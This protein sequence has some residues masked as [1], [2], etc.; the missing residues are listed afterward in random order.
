MKASAMIFPQPNIAYGSSNRKGAKV[1]QRNA[2]NNLVGLLP[3]EVK[4]G[5][6]CPSAFLEDIVLDLLCVP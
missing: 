3:Q 4:L 5:H 1:T 6:L 2:I